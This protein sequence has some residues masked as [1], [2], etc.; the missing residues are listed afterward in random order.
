M[1]MD[2]TPI[3]RPSICFIPF[4][5]ISIA[6]EGQ[7]PFPVTVKGGCSTAHITTISG[8]IQ[9]KLADS[10]I[11]KATSLEKC[12]QFFFRKKTEDIVLTLWQ[13]EAF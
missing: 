10:K 4:I 9:I 12:F 1:G 3:N 8:Q 13:V 7:A 11:E 6:S 5:I 2:L